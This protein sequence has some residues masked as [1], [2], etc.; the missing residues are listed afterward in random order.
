MFR[1]LK[2]RS[3]VQMIHFKVKMTGA[4]YVI[5]SMGC[6]RTRKLPLGFYRLLSTSK[7]YKATS[8]MMFIYFEVQ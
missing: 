4:S 5:V 6:E 2:A 1:G 8:N 7:F 3:K